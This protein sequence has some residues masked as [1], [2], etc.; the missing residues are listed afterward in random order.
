MAREK[1]F[2]KQEAKKN[3][4]LVTLSTQRRMRP[5]ISELIRIT[6]YPHLLDAEEVKNYPD[7]KGMGRN[8]WF[9]DHDHP[10]S[11][12]KEAEARSYMNVFEAEM[13][14]VLVKHLVRQGYKPQQIAVLTPYLEIILPKDVF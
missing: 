2:G 10:E 12:G 4:S 11:G 13:V 1:E 5:N 3:G 14:L 7:V 8:L 6:L 9:F